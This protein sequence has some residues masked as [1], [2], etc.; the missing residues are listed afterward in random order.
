MPELAQIAEVPAPIVPAQLKLP[1]GSIVQPLLEAP[2][3][4]KSDPPV[5]A[6][7]VRLVPAV[8]AEITGLAPAKVKLVE[9]KVLELIVEEKVEAPETLR[10]LESVAAPV[11]VRVPDKVVFPVTAKVEERVVAPLTIAVPA[12]FKV[13]AGEIVPTPKLPLPS[14]VMPEVPVPPVISPILFAPIRYSPLVVSLVNASPGAAAVPSA[15]STWPAKVGES[16]PEIVI[17]EPN[18]T[19][20]PP[21]RLVPA[22]TVTLWFAKA[23]LGIL[24][25]VLSDPEIVLLVTVWV[26]LVPTKVVVASGKVIVLVWVGVQVK[27]PEEKLREVTLG[28]TKV[29]E[30]LVDTS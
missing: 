12:T 30:E 17:D 7:I 23:E 21:V 18:S 1:E 4:N 8:E 3:A 13:A 10:V 26:V 19:S 27:V 9:V 20:P 28:E 16:L 2:P 11:V 25:K 14:M 29:G 5:P 24:V 22:V 15:R 6:L